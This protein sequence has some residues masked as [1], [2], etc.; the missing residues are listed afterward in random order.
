[1]APAKPTY[2]SVDIPPRAG[3]DDGSDLF[4]E[5][6]SKRITML[7]CVNRLLDSQN[8]MSK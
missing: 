7:L 5:P 2:D 8:S 3:S 4:E 6:A 1:M